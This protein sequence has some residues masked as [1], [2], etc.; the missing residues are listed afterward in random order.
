MTVA[1]MVMEL[2]LMSLVLGW[3]WV[4]IAGGSWPAPWLVLLAAPFGLVSGRL[5]SFEWRRRPWF[6]AVWWAVVAIIVAILAEGGNNIAA[7]EASGVRWNVQFAA[8]LLLAWRGWSL[9]EGWIDREFVEAELQLGTIL[10]LGMLLILVWVIPGAGLLPAVTFAAAGL[11]G[12]GLARRSERRAPGS[13]PESDWLVLVGGL[14][15]V[16]VLVAV[17]VVLLVTPDVLVAIVDQVQA[18]ANLAI[19]GIAGL[20]QWISNLFPSF[21]DA[22]GQ[23]QPSG[24][25]GDAPIAPPPVINRPVG[26]VPFFWVY[27]IAITFV[28]VTFLFFGIR[29]IIRL[30]KTNLRPFNIRLPKQRDPAPALSAADSFSWAGWWRA[31]WAWLRGEV[32]SG[33][34]VR[35]VLGRQA[36]QEASAAQRTAQ[37]AEQRSIRALYREFLTAVTRAGF[38]RE[39]STTP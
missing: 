11:T 24:P 27:E 19:V 36:P 2:S 34:L 7:G 32:L 17:A 12:L 35:T 14:V 30:M 6:D 22:A 13:S 16:V 28:L 26:E 29:A 31:F 3:V 38:E 21:G 1:V 33:S 4:V 5:V 25:I 37:Q 15:A 9:A 18:G 8:G 20:L 10:V 39:P 23:Q